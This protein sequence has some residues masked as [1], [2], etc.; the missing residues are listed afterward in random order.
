MD[1][2]N[3]NSDNAVGEILTA[4]QRKPKPRARSN[5]SSSSSSDSSSSSSSSSTSSP[6]RRHRKNKRVAKRKHHRTRN[7]KK[8]T[9]E[10]RNLRNQIACHNH[11]SQVSDNFDHDAIS[12]LSGVS[13]TFDEPLPDDRP[14]A[15]THCDEEFTLALETK[16]KEPSTPKTSEHHLKLLCEIQ[17]LNKSDWNEVR[18][19]ET[20]KLYNQTPGFTDIEMNE[21]VKAYDSPRHLVNADKAFAALTMCV[22]KQN[23]YLQ[24]TLRDLLTWARDCDSLNYESLHQKLN[25]LF[26]T[27]DFHKTSSDLLQMICGH[28]SDIIQMRRDYVTKQTKDPLVK[29]CL[30][31]IP[32][33]ATNLFDAEKF[34]AAIE[35]AGGV[36]KSFW[37][38]QK[39]NS[40]S[41]TQVDPKKP[42][43]PSQ[44]SAQFLK[45]SQGGF[46]ASNR[47][48]AQAQYGNGHPP[49]QG[50]WGHAC[51]YNSVAPAPNHGRQ[52]NTFRGNNYRSNAR[53][54]N[55]TNYGRKR[56]SSS[57]SRQNKDNKRRKY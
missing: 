28:R 10:I 29:T 27:G 19:A 52:Q 13:E 46:K 51:Q 26:S 1:E 5:S 23:E 3:R 57:P 11:V 22:L 15:S 54:Q 21:E 12:L 20:Q 33:T 43:G 7:H 2:S 30:R 50:G 48:Y 32:P 34:T 56:T 6:R 18:F 41:A 53:Q 4:P 40:N 49:P 37:P 14:N 24:K 36:R 39:A 55:Q 35:K 47:Q 25:D 44:E 31:K 38:V 45:P 8:L 17:H 42:R 9:K 16:L